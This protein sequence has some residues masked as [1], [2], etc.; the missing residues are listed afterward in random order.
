MKVESVFK[1]YYRRGNKFYFRSGN[2]KMV[3]TANEKDPGFK[4]MIR[5]FKHK[6]KLMVL[7]E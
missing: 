6:R 4:E 3:I 5:M 1:Y 2:E 7:A